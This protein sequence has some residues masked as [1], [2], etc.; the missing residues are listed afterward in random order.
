VLHPRLQTLILALVLPAAGFTA[1]DLIRETIELS[2]ADREVLLAAPQTYLYKP[3]YQPPSVELSEAVHI[4]TIENLKVEKYTSKITGELDEVTGSDTATT[5]QGWIRYTP[6]AQSDSRLYRPIV[7]CV[8]HGEAIN[9]IHCEDMSWTR[10]QTDDM[11][12][13]IKFNGDLSDQEVATI[14]DFVD[15]AGLVST[16]DDQTVTSDKIYQI[17]KYPLAG[18]R[19]NVY[20][21]TAKKGYTDVIYLAEATNAEGLSEFEI[22]EFKCGQQ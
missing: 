4:G 3:N 22:S 20:V 2:P 19:V 1:E 6:V 9:W 17:I 12:K 10:L 16:T 21:K 11:A 15:D 5:Y 14:Y 7:L 8:S 18:K 13:P